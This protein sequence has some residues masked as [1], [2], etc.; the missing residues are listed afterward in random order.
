MIK[1]EER[2]IQGQNQDL[3]VLKKDTILNQEK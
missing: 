1:E 2:E 3:E